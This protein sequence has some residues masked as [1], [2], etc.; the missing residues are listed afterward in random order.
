MTSLTTYVD[1]LK[2]T[3][4]FRD[5]V[6]ES[7][8]KPELLE[9]LTKVT[10]LLEET[11]ADQ[12]EQVSNMDDDDR[13]EMVQKWTVLE[14]KTFCR[15]NEWSGY[16]KL[17][18]DE[19][20]AF[21][22]GHYEEGSE[23]DAMTV[24]ELKAVCR[25]NG[26][27]GYS[28]L[29]RDDLLNLVKSSTAPIQTL[30]TPTSAPTVQAV[31]DPKKTVSWVVRYDANVSPCIHGDLLSIGICKPS[32]FHTIATFGD[33]YVGLTVETSRRQTTCTCRTYSSLKAI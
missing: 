3:I 1:Y 26:I 11:V 31:S 30:D 18:K 2:K 22:L 4:V 5:F 19:L 29:K 9:A 28:K 7:E 6:S 33:V 10:C 8:T 16:S 21:V 12:T 15:V 27:S 17:R 13:R 24:A 20:V 25:D 14:L 32:R 23:Y